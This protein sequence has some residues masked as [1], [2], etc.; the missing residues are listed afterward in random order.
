MDSQKQDGISD[1]QLVS[2]LNSYENMNVDDHDDSLTDSQLIEAVR[3]Y[4]SKL[5]IIFYLHTT[6][7]FRNLSAVVL[8]TN[9]FVNQ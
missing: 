7:S 1:S 8:I 9:T 5:S 4:E 2:A 3:S 6:K